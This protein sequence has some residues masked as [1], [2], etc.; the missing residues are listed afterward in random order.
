MND[1]VS[2]DSSSKKS[3][4]EPGTVVHVGERQV[5]ETKIRLI[6]FDT[7]QVEIAECTEI[8][9]LM[10]SK[11]RQ[12]VSWFRITGLHDVSLIERLGLDFGIHRLVLEDIVNTHQRPKVEEFEN[13]VFIVFRA[14]RFQPEELVF[15]NEQFSI[16]LGSNYIL[17]FE[18]SDSGL[19]QPI[20]DRIKSSRGKFRSQ[21]ADYL[22][23]SIIDLVVDQ[24]FL[25]EDQLDE[26][27]ESFED[28]LLSTPEPEMMH[29]IQKLK[30]GMIFLRR[31]VSPLRELL[32]ALLRSESEF[33]SDN[34]KIYIRDVY[35]HAIRVIE[36]LD[37][38]R[39][40]IAGLLEIYLSSLSN[41]MNEIMKVLT[42]FATIFIPL[43]FFAG[44]YGMNF[45]FMPELKWQWSYPVFW[46]IVLMTGGGLLVF[47][48]NKKWL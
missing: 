28:E 15:Y 26:V 44:V 30:R 4:L 7:N 16:I 14:I 8:E 1:R 45:E 3:G 41:K 6:E 21:G 29:R 34:T 17:S 2:L 24:Y 9:N 13:F 37:S 31:A 22:A 40:L 38:Y 5:E 36:G 23:Y 25:I 35:D 33:I 10:P 27:I 19:L 18:E 20:S 47:F 48:R 12:T 43:T 39:D 32:S 46:L 11:Y 42:V